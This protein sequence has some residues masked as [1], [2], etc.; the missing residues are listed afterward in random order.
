M[1][2]SV[3]S[4]GILEFD[5]AKDRTVLV[6]YFDELPVQGLSS[7]ELVRKNI[8]SALYGLNPRLLDIDQ[9]HTGVVG[10]DVR[11]VVEVEVVP[12]HANQCPVH[13]LSCPVGLNISESDQYI[14]GMPKRPP[15]PQETIKIRRLPTKGEPVT[16][17]GTVTRADGDT[18]TFRIPGY[19]IPVTVKAAYLSK[20]DD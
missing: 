3:R 16:I 5:D 18:V 9:V 12:R 4:Q 15:N 20:Q 10:D 14:R 11:T 8:S 6:G 13:R 2:R 17:T 1:D 19:D 7:S